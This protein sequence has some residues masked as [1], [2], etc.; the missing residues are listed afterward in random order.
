[1]TP[2]PIEERIVQ[3][4]AAELRGL[5]ARAVLAVLELLDGGATVPFIAR[6]RKEKT[7]ALDE[8]AIRRIDETRKSLVDLDKRRATIL[9]A[10]AAD[11]QLTPALE[12]A[13]LAAATKAELEDLYLPFKMS[14]PSATPGSAVGDRHT[15]EPPGLPS[16]AASL[17][18]SGGRY[19][20]FASH[21]YD[22][23]SSRQARLELPEGGSTT[24]YR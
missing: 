20:R 9:A 19:V 11:H 24:A 4:L 5:A 7:G 1:M 17:V 8:V 3:A 23:G 14:I 2:P 21:V 13:L 22:A 6:Y 15:R 18:E 16:I 12:R 10:I